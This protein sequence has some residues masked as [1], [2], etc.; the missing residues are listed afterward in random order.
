MADETSTAVLSREDAISK[1][2]TPTGR[3]LDIVPVRGLGMFR[4]TFVDEKP[5]KLPDEISGMYTGVAHAKS[6][7]L[8]YLNAFWDLSDENARS[9]PLAKTSATANAVSR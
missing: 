9:K 8:R 2:M 4:I 6:A 5:G 1:Y 7:L 3:V